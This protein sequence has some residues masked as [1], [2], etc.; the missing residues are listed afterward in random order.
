MSQDSCYRPAP[1]TYYIARE[2]WPFVGGGFIVA[3][4]AQLLG[5]SILAWV[6]SFFAAFSLYFFRNPWRKIPD[7]PKA[8]ISPADGRV[9]QICE[10]AKSEFTNGPMRQV[11]IFMS[12]LNVHV[13]RFPVSGVVK[14]VKYHPGKFLMASLDKASLENER[15]SFYMESSSGSPIVFTQIAGWLARRIICYAQAGDK[16]VVGDRCGLIRFGSRVDVLLPIDT[17]LNVSKNQNVRAG[18]TILGRLP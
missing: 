8:V 11:S 3:I 9:V 10:I 5:W 13:N 1:R 15:N 18:E 14:D 6:A 17:V 7:D 16:A 4:I 2:G 12:P